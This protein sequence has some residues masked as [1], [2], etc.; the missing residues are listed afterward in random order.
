MR[1][2]GGLNE[3]LWSFSLKK[4]Q[5]LSGLC[6]SCDIHCRKCSLKYVAGICVKNLQGLEMKQPRAKAGAFAHCPLPLPAVGSRCSGR[7]VWL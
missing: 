2:R 7:F 5:E 4:S 3:I 1:L 6:V